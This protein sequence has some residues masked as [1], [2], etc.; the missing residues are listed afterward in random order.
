MSAPSMEDSSRMQGVS[1]VKGDLAAHPPVQPGIA[2]TD[3]SV[4]LSEPE[5]GIWRPVPLVW[6]SVAWHLACLLALVWRPGDWPYWLGLLALNHLLLTVLVF[7]PRNRWL[8]RTLTRLPPDA[9]GRRQVALTFDDGPDPVVTPQVLDLLD[10]HGARASFF[11]IGSRVRQ[12]PELVREIVARGHTV[13]NHG[14]AHSPIFALWGMA[15]MRRDIAAM[16]QSLRDA[17]VPPARFFRPTA[18]FRNPLLDPVL[19]RMGLQLAM[20][21]RRS[22]DTRDGNPARV[23]ARLVRGLSAGDIL[24]LHDGN[25]AATTDGR[26]V[27][28]EVLPQLLRRLQQAGLQP[29]PLR[30]ALAPQTSVP[31]D[32]DAQTLLARLAHQDP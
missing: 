11:C 21:E 15:R 28:L 6:I 2:V 14:D 17:G 13:E 23:L 30:E 29:V 19:A 16:Q 18:G 3:G 9:R 4:E 24:L 8:G 31:P 5:S 7:L 10:R 22:F 27:V 26:P 20:W 25:S 12:H 32:P 1:P